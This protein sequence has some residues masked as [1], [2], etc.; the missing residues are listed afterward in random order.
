[1]H[2]I[3]L[4]VLKNNL[5]LSESIKRIITLSSGNSFQP[6]GGPQG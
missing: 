3:S 5:S 4:N 1:M 6:A 2:Y